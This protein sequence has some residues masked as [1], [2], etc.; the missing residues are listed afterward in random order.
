MSQR[1]HGQEPSILWQAVNL[2]F[3]AISKMALEPFTTGVLLYVLTRTSPSV[4][5][6]PLISSIQQAGISPTRLPQI[7][8]VLKG[9]FA[10]GVVRRIHQ[11]LSVLATNY[12]HFRWQ[13]MPWNFGDRERSEVI[14][15]TGGCSGFGALMTKGFAGEAKIVILDI[16]DLPEELAKRMILSQASFGRWLNHDSGQCVLLQM[17]SG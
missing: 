16:L 6:D 4:L 1:R 11:M 13:G 15:L 2:P 8:P 3:Q 5:K 10:L 14:V 9:L 7:L 17:R 12:W